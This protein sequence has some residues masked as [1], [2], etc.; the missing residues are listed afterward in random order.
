MKKYQHIICPIDLSEHSE[1]VLQQAIEFQ[2]SAG[3]KLTVVHFIEPMAATAYNIGAIDIQERIAE[4]AKNK[5][6][7][8]SD[9][10]ALNQDDVHVIAQHPKRAIDTFAKEIKADLIVMGH[11]QHSFIGNILGSTASAVANRTPCDVFIV[12]N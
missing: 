7:E 12:K 5:I 4:S 1:A 6:A 11:G 10:Y 2:Q 8:L 9:K 3:A